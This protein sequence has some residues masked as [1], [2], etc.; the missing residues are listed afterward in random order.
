[1]SYFQYNFRGGLNRQD[2]NTKIGED[3]YYLLLNG[4]TRNNTLKPIKLPVELENRPAGLLQGVYSVGTY[5]LIFVAGRA[6]YRDLSAS[7]SNFNPI[8]PLVLSATAPVIYMQ[9]VP[10]S[11]SNFTRQLASANING[12]VN[13]FNTGLGVTSSPACALVQD[14]VGQPW[15]IFGDGSCRVTQEYGDW[16]PSSREY[17]PIGTLMLYQDAI[18]YLLAKDLNGRYTQIYRSVSGRPLDFMVNI[19]QQGDKLPT[20]LEGGAQSVSHRVDYDEVTAMQRLDTEDRSFFASTLAASYF[21]VPIFDRTIFGEPT[22]SNPSLFSSGTLNQFSFVDILGDRAFVTKT[23]IRSFNA[24]LQKKNEG[25]NAPFSATINSFFE[26]ITQTTSAAITFDNYAMFAVNTVHGAGVMVF[27]TLTQKFVALD[28]YTG[29]SG[30]I[31]QFAEV[32]YQGSVPRLFFITTDDKIY[33]W[34]AS[35]STAI[36]RF[37]PRE[38]TTD[39]PKTEQ[40]CSKIH[41]IF[42]NIQASG[43]VNVSLYVDKNYCGSSGNSIDSETFMPIVNPRPLPYPLYD[44]SATKN[45]TFDFANSAKGW[46]LGMFIEW[47]FDAELSHFIIESLPSTQEVSQ[48][49]QSVQQL[50]TTTSSILKA[51]KLVVVGNDGDDN[52]DRRLLFNALQLQ[53]PDY[54]LGAGNHNYPS[55]ELATQQATLRQYWNTLK[56]QSKVYFAL[57]RVDLDT[58]VGKAHLDYFR[59]PPPQR[60]FQKVVGN[61]TEVFI[62]NSGIQSNGLIVEPDGIT[63]TSIQALWLRDALVASTKKWKIVLCN[64]PPYTSDNYYTPGRLELRWPFRLWGASLVISGNPLNYERLYVDGLYYINCG[65]S[66]KGPFSG[67]AEVPLLTSLVRYNAYLNYLLLELDSFNLR[68]RV[69]NLDGNTV[70]QFIVNG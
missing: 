62:L 64:M 13:F 49:Q 37:Y 6:Y 22:F 67:F 3:E 63:D 68:A 61:N 4:R 46:K 50:V 26:G 39:D 51:D 43:K 44:R 20:E 53:K 8:N 17:V 10:A 60:Y 47:D 2:D 59:Y 45:L 24:V 57:G 23:G 19:T 33:E 69:I 7:T 40:Q 38:F 34:G 15:V 16:T 11:T 28:I 66:G 27:D 52:S 12:D 58:L 1:M 29:I 54:F 31:K 30:L 9:L 25:R 65:M 21:V 55:G 70:D 32:S 42:T 41:T 56:L 35:S 14:G 18:L 5:L 36:C 48:E